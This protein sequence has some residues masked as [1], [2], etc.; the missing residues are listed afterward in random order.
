MQDR[1]KELE[2]QVA[3]LERQVSVLTVKINNIL[4]KNHL[5]PA[6][7]KWGS[8]FQQQ[9]NDFQRRF[10]PVTLQVTNSPR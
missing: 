4:A 7:G 3:A 8:D 10:P 9:Y 2:Q 6:F 5:E 1:I